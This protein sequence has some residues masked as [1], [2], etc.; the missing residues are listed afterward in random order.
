[1][2]QSLFCKLCGIWGVI[3]WIIP[4]S[5]PRSTKLRQK[6]FGRQKD[7]DPHVEFHGAC[8]GGALAYQVDRITMPLRAQTTRSWWNCKGT[9]GLA[10]HPRPTERV[11]ITRMLLTR[12]QTLCRST[13][14][15]R[16]WIVTV[17]ALFS[18]S[19]PPPSPLPRT[20]S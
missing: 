16:T 1:M 10:F 20:A 14:D 12:D 5:P 4:V 19:R 3:P 17:V 7:F 6:C 9:Y 18:C 8:P 2:A 13:A 15:S 11:G